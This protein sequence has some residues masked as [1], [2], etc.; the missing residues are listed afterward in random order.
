MSFLDRLLGR[1]Q[2][3]EGSVLAKT[4]MAVSDDLIKHMQAASRSNDPARAL[5]ADIWAQHHNVPYMTTMYEANAEMMSALQPG[6]NG[7]AN[8]DN[9]QS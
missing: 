5:L 4:A 2:R 7:S 3:Q 8:N 1:H 9:D 6:G